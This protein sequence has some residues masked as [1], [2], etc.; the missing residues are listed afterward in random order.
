LGRSAV[1]LELPQ[2]PAAPGSPSR[3]AERSSLEAEV[4]DSGMAV[5]VVGDGICKDGQLKGSGVEGQFAAVPESCA[6]RGLA[7]R[8][9]ACDLFR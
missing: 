1:S 8:G 4:K 9:L 6:S 2:I 3:N 5:P 7:Y